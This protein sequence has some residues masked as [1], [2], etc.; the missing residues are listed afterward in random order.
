VYIPEWIPGG[1]WYAYDRYINIVRY[2]VRNTLIRYNPIF[3]VVSPSVRVVF[4]VG[5]DRDSW[6][7]SQK[8]I[9]EPPANDEK[10]LAPVEETPP[11]GAPPIE[12]DDGT[13]VPPDGDGDTEVPPDGDGD[14]EVPPDGDGDDENGPPD[15]DGDTEGTSRRRWRHRSTSRRRWRR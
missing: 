9:D 3:N 5:G 8:D 12:P 15:G 10:N 1:W 4:K 13:E 2:D 6:K 14:T 11:E 7:N